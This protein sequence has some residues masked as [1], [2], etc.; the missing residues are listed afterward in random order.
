MNVIQLREVIKE[1][2]NK[3][4]VIIDKIIESFRQD[5]DSK[6]ALTILNLL[7]KSICQFLN[8]KEEDYRGNPVDYLLKKDF[9]FNDRKFI[10]ICPN[11]NNIIVYY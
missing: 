3:P 8:F 5:I 4:L 7:A 9:E 10:A 11:C 6:D 1:Y 2:K